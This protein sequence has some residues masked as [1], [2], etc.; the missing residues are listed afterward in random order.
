MRKETRWLSMY[1]SAIVRYTLK[2]QA[3]AWQAFFKRLRDHPTFHTKH[4]NK[5]FTAP[6]G[7]FKVVDDNIRIQKV[8]WMK[9]RRHGGNPW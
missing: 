7:A 9:M 3:E 2:G 6:K 4:M 1:S 5:S 8:G